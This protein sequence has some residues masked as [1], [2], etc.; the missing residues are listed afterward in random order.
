[1]KLTLR[2]E[3]RLWPFG[4]FLGLVDLKAGVTLALLFALF[5]KVA[6]VYGLIA[7]MTGAGGSFAQISLYVYSVVAL[8]ALGWGLKAVKE[9][10]PKRTLYFAHLFFADHVFST[11]WTV[12]FAVVW[13]VYTPHDGRRQANSE[14]QKKMMEGGITGGHVMTDEEREAAAMMIWNHE[15]GTAAAVIAVSWLCKIYLALLIYS[16][17]V[18]LRKGSYRSLPLSRSAVAPSMSTDPSYLPEEDDEEIGL[19]RAPLHTPTGN[20]ISSFAELAN[21]PDRSRRIKSGSS[22]G[23]SASILRKDEETPEEVLFDE[24]ELASSRSQSKMGTDDSAVS[25]SSQEETKPYAAAR[26]RV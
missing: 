2:P 4:S 25:I 1:M 20:S 26:G 16:Y 15:K 24:V 11:A 19:Y 3:W 9:E 21:A 13:W 6:G 5:N 8:L 7:M 18:H 12:Y 10:D 23:R 17:A 14:A 22:L